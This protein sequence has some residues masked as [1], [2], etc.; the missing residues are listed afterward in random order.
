MYVVIG[1]LAGVAVPIPLPPGVV[2][3]VQH[4]SWPALF[5]HFWAPLVIFF[6]W[7][8]VHVS[9]T[10]IA[11]RLIFEMIDEEDALSNGSNVKVTTANAF[12]EFEST[13]I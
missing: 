1:V 5:S 4:S 3:S 2:N 8:A 12:K 9:F 13:R 6:V 7:I 11:D 10:I